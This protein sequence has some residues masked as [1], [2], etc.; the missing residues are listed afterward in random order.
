MTVSG[1]G[2]DAI[3]GAC[4]HESLPPPLV[5]GLVYLGLMAG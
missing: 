3:S 1:C 2:T 5:A 4:S